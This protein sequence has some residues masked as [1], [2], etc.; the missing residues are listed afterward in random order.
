[1]RARTA[2]S[3]RTA[4][5]ALAALAAALLLGGCAGGPGGAGSAPAA[6]VP[7]T[8][9]ATAT[10]PLDGYHPLEDTTGWLPPD[11]FHD[12][13]DRR[14]YLAGRFEAATALPVSFSGL[15]EVRF[16]DGT[17]LTLPQRSARATLDALRTA[18][19]GCS[20]DCPVL[21][22][23]AARPG[24]REVT[25]TRG[26]ATVPTWEF[27]LAGYPEPFRYPAVLPQ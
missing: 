27:T 26:P 12:D 2:R 25:T 14:A 8:A 24:T 13:A 16:A 11:A 10:A 19:D 7:A 20:A 18:P 4:L 17:A 5:T 6:T 22:V 3:A 23:T 9:T 15:T 1:M 21:T